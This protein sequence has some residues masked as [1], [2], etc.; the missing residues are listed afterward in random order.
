MFMLTD[1]PIRV[2]TYARYLHTVPVRYV[3]LL[4]L[5]SHHTDVTTQIW[6]RT[7][8][9]GWIPSFLESPLFCSCMR[10]CFRGDCC[11]CAIEESGLAASRQRREQGQRAGRRCEPY[12]P[13]RDSSL[14]VGTGDADGAE[15]RC[16]KTGGRD[17]AGA[18]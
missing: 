2:G 13:G 7:F 1:Q 5:L 9:K 6:G 16:S 17:G 11:A 10:G 12:G 3:V 4:R 18:C 8:Q 15:P 14:E